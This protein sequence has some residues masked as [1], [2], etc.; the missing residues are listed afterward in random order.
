MSISVECIELFKQS[1]WFDHIDKKIVLIGAGGKKG[2]EYFELLK[3]YITFVA[4]IQPHPSEAL[5]LNAQ[6]YNIP[7][8]HDLDQA[9][10]YI[11][12]DGAIISVPHHLHF[13][14]T[15]QCLEHNMF[16]IKE[17][18]FVIN[19]EE[20]DAYK[21]I[22]GNK[23]PQLFVIVQRQ[24]QQSF[25][26]AKKYL[27]SLGKIFSF[28]YEYSLNLKNV[29]TNG[30]RAKK[31][32]SGGGALLDMG[33]HSIDILN[34]FFGIPL[35]YLAVSTYKTNIMKEES[36]EDEMFIV[37]SYPNDLIG[38]I[39]ISRYGSTKKEY[40][41]IA[42]DDGILV[43]TPNSYVVYDKM[44]SIIRQEQ[45]SSQKEDL[46]KMFLCY[47]NNINNIE[48]I[49]NELKRHE[50]NNVLISNIYK[51]KNVL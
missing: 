15:K 42:G 51:I 31:S 49:N 7:I 36:L 12:C 30:W 25:I 16:V 4:F 22:C 10:Q 14:Y 8:Y 34:A 28:R 29:I 13:F 9:L 5:V 11:K 45:T 18:P 17:K 23:T 21:K 40:L 24:F 19:Q 3:D 2:S 27:N 1:D 32:L 35:N 41:E 43:I 47:L 33:Y 37:L 6:K 39:I 20:I 38:N 46:L 50:E 26:E 48:Y 44:G